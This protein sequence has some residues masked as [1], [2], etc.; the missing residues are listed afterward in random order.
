MV[1]V[2]EETQMRGRYK[3]RYIPSRERIVSWNLLKDADDQSKVS[4]SR[5]KTTNLKPT[6]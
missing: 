5:Y 3:T 2:S 1:K 6:N 4:S